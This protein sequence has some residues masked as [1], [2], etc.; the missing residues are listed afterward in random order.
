MDINHSILVT[1]FKYLADNLKDINGFFRMDLTEIQSSF[2]SKIEFPALVLESHEGNFEASNVQSTVN[3]RTFAFTIYLKPLKS[4]Y[5]D[6][7]QKLSS[8]ETIGLKV[9]ARMKHDATLPNHFLYNRFKVNTVSY[10]KVG[11]VFNEQLYGYR[12]VGSILGT[13][14]LIVVPSDWED[15]PE[16]CS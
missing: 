9:I 15:L 14:P 12:F 4:D 2:R 13:E 16:I 11:P 3:D 1:Y 10:A 7:N 6:Q 8:A 5:D